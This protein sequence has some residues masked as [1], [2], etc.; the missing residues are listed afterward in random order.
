M[1]TNANGGSGDILNDREFITHLLLTVGIDINDPLKQSAPD[2]VALQ[3]IINN[4]R[5][6]NCTFEN[7][8]ELKYCE[9][10]DNVKSGGSSRKRKRNKRNKSNKIIKNRR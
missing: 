6:K 10:C 3:A 4:W 7:N 9:M 2:Y 1:S 8:K 5:C